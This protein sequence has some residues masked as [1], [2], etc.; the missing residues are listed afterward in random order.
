MSVFN[1]SFCCL[2]GWGFII[3]SVFVGLFFFLSFIGYCLYLYIDLGTKDLIFGSGIGVLHIA[4]ATHIDVS[5]LDN[6]LALQSF[7]SAAGYW[8]ADILKMGPF[9]LFVEPPAESFQPFRF[10]FVN[11]SQ[12]M[13]VEFPLLLLLVVFFSLGGLMLRGRHVA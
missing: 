11:D 3:A 9:H 7:G 8:N 5:S 4:V 2:A 10:D 1:R 13:S 6:D 12:Y